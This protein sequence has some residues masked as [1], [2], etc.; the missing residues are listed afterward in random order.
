MVP[1]LFIAGTAKTPSLSHCRIFGSKCHY[2]LPKSKIKNL[3]PKSREA[4]FVGYAEQT[5]G[6]KLWDIENRKCIIC[7]DVVFAE[8]VT[9]SPVSPDISVSPDSSSEDTSNPGGDEQTRFNSISEDISDK[10]SQQTDSDTDNDDDYVE[11]S[12]DPTVEPDS[13]GLR[14]ST[15]PRKPPSEWWKSSANIALSARIVPQSYKS[16]MSQ[17]NIDFWT[18]GIEKE[19]S[20]L[21][22]NK[23]WTLVDR[24]PE[25]HVLPCKYVFRVKNGSPKARLV[26]LGCRQLYGIDYLETFAPVVKLTT[27]R[28]LLATAAALDFE[29]EQMDVVTAFLNGDLQED[30]YMQI[31]EGL[32]T[33]ENENKVCKL[34]KSLYGLKQAPRQW[35]AK[36]HHYLCT[37]LNFT[38]STDDPCLYIRKR[39]SCITI[40]AL[41]VDDLLILGS[42]KD[43]ITLIKN[44]FSRRFEMKDLGQAKVMLGIEITRDRKNRKLFISQEQYVTE[45]LK[46]F[47]MNESRSVA[48]PMEKSALSVIDTDTEIAP[49]DTPY[50]QAIGS[51]IYLVSGTRPDLAFCV[52]RLSQ[53]LEKPQKHHW[54]AVKR[55]LRYLRGTSTHGILYD[56]GIGA[57]L[58]GYADSDFAGC[59]Q[60]RKSTSGYVFLLAGGAISWKSKKQSIVATSSCEAE[61]ISSCM[62]S[63]EAIWL[64]RLCASL[65]PGYTHEPVNIK[66]DNN[67]A[68]DLARNATINERTKHIDVRFHFI[69]QCIQDGKV[70]LSRC[71]TSNQVADPLTKPLDR[72]AHL[73]HCSLQ[74][75]VENQTRDSDCSRGSVEMSNI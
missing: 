44:E 35:Y 53:Y 12:N 73:K 54:T 50:R 60:S 55:V 62:A 46:R 38:S 74:G 5:K 32:R 15:R 3:D 66:V 20:C 56:G 58:V 8:E 31:P 75:L 9:E 57:T 71:D 10:E 36:I 40:I 24:S 70:H 34:Q 6:Y 19:H 65:N 37:D 72:I 68:K 27:I 17:E 18:P 4:I 23:T 33:P 29:I 7:R 1:L 59:T 28:V 47:N 11:A 22:R 30:I 41:Y 48:T 61:Y 26:A 13:S 51:L 14:R 67:G 25:M 52:R 45:I 64:A 39:N 69:R 16:A 42:S 21:I 49:E 63:K 2:I 43:E